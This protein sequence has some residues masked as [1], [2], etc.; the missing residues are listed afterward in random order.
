MRQLSTHEAQTKMAPLAL[1]IVLAPSLINGPDP[2][3]DAE[4]CLQPGKSLPLAL[5]GVKGGE[6]EGE[7]GTLVG[8][9][10]MWIREDRDEMDE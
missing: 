1:A 2:L 8:L 9:L 5:R 7:K 3:A 4:M 6:E 10:E